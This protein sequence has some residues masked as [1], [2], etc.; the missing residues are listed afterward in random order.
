MTDLFDQGDAAKR[1]RLRALGWQLSEYPLRSGTP[2]RLWVP[3]SGGQP[4]TEARAFS[5]LPMSGAEG[6]NA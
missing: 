4:V 3:P 5:L 2:I 6:T 1:E